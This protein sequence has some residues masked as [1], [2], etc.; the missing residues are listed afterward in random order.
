M[1]KLITVAV[2]SG[3]FTLAANASMSYECW[4]YQSGSPYK[5]VHVSADNKSQA[6]SKAQVKFND[7]GVRYDYVSC[8]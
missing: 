7:L 3:F 6:E 2:L 4:A 8:K 1:K 5:M